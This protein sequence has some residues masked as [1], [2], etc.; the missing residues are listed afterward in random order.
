[1]SLI[2]VTEASFKKEVLLAEGPVLV[3]FWASWC[4]PC[5]MLMGT[6]EQIA[7]DT[8]LGF[9]IVKIDVDENP[10]LSTEYGV[11]S[12]PT[13]ILFKDGKMVD[14]RSGVLPASRLTEWLKQSTSV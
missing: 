5:R 12:L 1:M 14:M 6:L 11:K 7:E 10:E 9:K 13:L 4:A 2:V 8:S 3:D